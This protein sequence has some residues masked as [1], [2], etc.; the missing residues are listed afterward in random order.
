LGFAVMCI[1]VG[2]MTV[3]QIANLVIAAV[4][5]AVLTGICLFSRIRINLNE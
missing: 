1:T 2:I 4:V 3:T 5:F